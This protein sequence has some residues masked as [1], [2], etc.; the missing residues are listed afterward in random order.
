MSRLSS[1]RSCRVAVFAVLIAT[2]C[3]LHGTAMAATDSGGSGS[4]NSGSG[5]G[6]SPNSGPGSHGRSE[7]AGV[8]TPADRVRESSTSRAE[9]TDSPATIKGHTW[10]YDVGVVSYSHDAVD[11]LRS[12]AL[13]YVPVGITYGVTDR[14]EVGVS[15]SPYG[16][17]WL[18]NTVAQTTDQGSGVG[19]YGVRAKVCWAGND[20]SAFAVG[21]SV[22][23]SFAPAVD[24][25][26]P[27][28]DGGV[29]VPLRVELGSGF[30]LGAMG[31]VDLRN[32]PDDTSQHAEYV[33]SLNLSHDIREHVSGFL[34]MVHASSALA[35]QASLTAVDAGVSWDVFA[36][37][38]LSTAITYGVSDGRGDVGVLAGLGVHLT[39]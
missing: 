9:V 16:S 24:G 37:V 25:V 7:L 39:R 27:K 20:S 18:R 34:E 30:V 14:F 12:D 8:F 6:K 23:A 38:G 29:R 4:G 13:E 11:S 3:L 1:L 15:A 32:D 19:G 17:D 35:T 2:S 10:A 28:P 26:T 36:H 31:E 33:E 21:T 5:K 22:F